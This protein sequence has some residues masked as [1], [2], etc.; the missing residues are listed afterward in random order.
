MYVYSFI[1]AFSNL[2]TV[3]SSYIHRNPHAHTHT[4]RRTYIGFYFHYC[5]WNNAMEAIL[6]FHSSLLNK[7]TSIFG[8]EFNQQNTEY[9][10]I[11]LKYWNRL[12]MG[13]SKSGS[14][15]TLL[16]SVALFSVCVCVCA[17]YCFS[18]FRL[19]LYLCCAYNE[20]VPKTS[21]QL[22]YKASA[23]HSSIAIHKHQIKSWPI[24]RY[25]LMAGDSCD[26]AAFTK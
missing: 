3:Q 13:A 11:E 16:A 24:A 8:T 20:C 18:R 4:E 14:G 25:D 5:E 7:T 21:C 23:P 9:C 6:Q 1:V 15:R 10:Y 19:P 22:H 17:V 2:A 26:A 12:K